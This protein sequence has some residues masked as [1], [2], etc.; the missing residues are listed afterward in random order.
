MQALTVG[1]VPSFVDIALNFGSS[2]LAKD[3]IINQLVKKQKKIV[4]YGDDTWIKLFPDMF[5]RQEGTTSFF[6]SDF[7]EVNIKLPILVFSLKLLNIL[8][9]QVDT[10]VTRNVNEELKRDDWD[11]MIL[12][13]LGLDHIGHVEGSFS[14]KISSKLQEMDAIIGKLNEHLLNWVIRITWSPSFHFY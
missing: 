7:F 8:S 5:T 13:Y 6:V 4:F 10:N 9:F 2:R 12:H 14:S 1:T 11:V 3:S